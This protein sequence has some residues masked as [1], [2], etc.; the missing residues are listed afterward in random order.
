MMNDD[1]TWNSCC[2]KRA[3]RR[4]GRLK[5]KEEEKKRACTWSSAYSKHRESGFDDAVARSATVV[6]STY[7]LLRH[8]SQSRS[9]CGSRVAYL[10]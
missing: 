10:E 5:K 1:F 6:L 3:G 8:V 9:D 7:I 2:S 4:Q